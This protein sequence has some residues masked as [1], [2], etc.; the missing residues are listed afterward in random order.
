[1]GAPPEGATRSEDGLY[2]WDGENWQLIAEEPE[3]NLSGSFLQTVLASSGAIA[4][5][6][7]KVLI[8]DPQ[9]K[10]IHDADPSGFTE[11]IKDIIEGA[12]AQ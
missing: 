10:V 6:A 8:E 3:D 5:D 11:I 9:V 4:D 2:W 1:M 7:V 12:A